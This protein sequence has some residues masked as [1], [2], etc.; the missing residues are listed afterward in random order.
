MAKLFLYNRRADK[1][2]CGLM[3]RGRGI[4]VSSC[5]QLGC[6]ISYDLMCTALEYKL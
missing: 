5:L 1:A 4:T 2:R 6:F 3:A